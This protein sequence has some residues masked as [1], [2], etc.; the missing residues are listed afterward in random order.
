MS[1]KLDFGIRNLK[2]LRQYPVQNL[3]WRLPVVEIERIWEKFFN[4]FIPIM[5]SQYVISVVISLVVFTNESPPFL[6]LFSASLLLFVLS[7]AGVR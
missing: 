1:S 5:K 4:R 6:Y 2:L 3:K 7:T